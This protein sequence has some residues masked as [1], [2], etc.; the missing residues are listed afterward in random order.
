M[1]QTGLAM[2]AVLAV[3]A[4][5]I[6]WAAGSGDGRAT[7]RCTQYLTICGVGPSGAPSCI[8]PLA[9]AGGTC[10]PDDR[11]ATKWDWRLQERFGDGMIELKAT[12]K[13][14]INEVDGKAAVGMHTLRF[15]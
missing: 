2:A 11:A 9:V 3:L 12:G 15:N 4:W 14:K 6:A 1:M 7:E 5:P 13:H 8:A 10:A